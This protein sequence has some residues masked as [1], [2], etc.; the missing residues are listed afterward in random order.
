M[1]T[2]RWIF[3]SSSGTAR[4]MVVARPSHLTG[5][6]AILSVGNVHLVSMRTVV[7][8]TGTSTFC[9]VSDVMNRWRHQL[10]S[11][12]RRSVPNYLRLK[13]YDLRHEQVFTSTEIISLRLICFF[14]YLTVVTELDVQHSWYPNLPLYTVRSQLHP[15]LLLTSHFPNIHSFS[16]PHLLHGFSNCRLRNGF[17]P[18]I[19]RFLYHPSYLHDSS[20]CRSIVDW[21]S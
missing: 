8:V 11:A 10:R 18:K 13:G 5:L 17:P 20:S 6:I 16:V 14:L 21:L 1:I 4:W 19:V 3:V 15:L 7:S 2:L 12:V 9:H